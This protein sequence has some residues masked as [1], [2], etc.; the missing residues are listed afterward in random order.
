M[1]PT[2]VRY[3]VHDVDRAVD[4]YAD[5]LGFHVEMRPAPGFSMVSRE[6]LRLLLGVSGAGG[7]GQ[8]TSDGGSP[9]R[10]DGIASSSRFRSGRR[11]VACMGAARPD[12][13]RPHPGEWRRPAPTLLLREISN[14]E[15]HYHRLR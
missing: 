12:S 1:E 7:A 2:N 10:G 9:S 13:R 4:F 15:V 3:I 11:G 8:S 6:G 14:A 5:C